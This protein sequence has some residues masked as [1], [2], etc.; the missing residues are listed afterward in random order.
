MDICSGVISFWVQK[1]F[2]TFNSYELDVLISNISR[3]SVS[4]PRNFV[5]TDCDEKKIIL[6][7]QDHKTNNC[8]KINYLK[9]NRKPQ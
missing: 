9:M 7:Y 1:I 3:D 5:K 4:F 8:G 2:E 6:L